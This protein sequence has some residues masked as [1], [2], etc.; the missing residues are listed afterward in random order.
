MDGI[1]LDDIEGYDRKTLQRLCKAE[2]IKAN[3]KTAF[4]RKELKQRVSDE[5]EENTP[6]R[7][8]PEMDDLLKSPPPAAATVHDDDDSKIVVVAVEQFPDEGKQPYNT[9]GGGSG[10]AAES[11]AGQQAELVAHIYRIATLE[12]DLRQ[13]NSSK[14]RMEQQLNKAEARAQ[15]LEG[16]M[17]RMQGRW[18]RALAEAE[19]C[20]QA[21]VMARLQ[22]Q[23]QTEKAQMRADS[24]ARVARKIA[25]AKFGGSSGATAGAAASPK[26]K[27]TTGKVATAAAAAAA[28]AGA[29]RTAPRFG[30]HSIPAELRSAYTVLRTPESVAKIPGLSQWRRGTG[31]RTSGQHAGQCPLTCSPQKRK[32]KV[33]LD[34]RNVGDGGG[35]GGSS[36][37]NPFEKKSK[38]ARTPQTL[39]KKAKA[40]QLLQQQQLQQ[41]NQFQPPKMSEGF[42]FG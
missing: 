14:A 20:A 3:G 25:A 38:L 34:A 41:R 42:L 35:G 1:T 22:A 5:Q 2:G 12:A 36:S 26:P 31:T 24:L 21:K 9:S 32:R 30:G 15:E 28:A 10:N 19:V 13:A 8:S 6:A 7:V 11:V 17:A 33:L 4:M 29:P 39:K 37:N 23:T 27:G 16:E 18:Q 40:R